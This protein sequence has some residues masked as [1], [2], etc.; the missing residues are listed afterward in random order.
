MSVYLDGTFGEGFSA[1]AKAGFVKCTQAQMKDPEYLRGKGFPRYRQEGAGD[2][3]VS[4]KAI[5]P[6][7]NPQQIE[8]ME[9]IKELES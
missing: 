6:K 5:L 2:M 4:I 1:K 9:K 8:L 3:I 7:L